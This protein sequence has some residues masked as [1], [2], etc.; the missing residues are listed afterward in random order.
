MT[1]LDVLPLA[2]RRLGPLAS[3][4]LVAIETPSGV[5]VV[6]SA[7][8]STPTESGAEECLC[9]V[10]STEDGALADLRAQL[11]GVR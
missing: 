1:I 7:C 6:A 10:A 9:A 11:G 4:R 8:R 5:S 3:V 2:R